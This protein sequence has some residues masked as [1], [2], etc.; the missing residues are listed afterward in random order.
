MWLWCPW[1]CSCCGAPCEQP[2]CLELDFLSRRCASTHSD[3]HVSARLQPGWPNPH[4]AKLLGLR[5]PFRS[6]PAERATTPL[7]LCSSL[8]PT[9]ETRRSR[10]NPARPIGEKKRTFC[11]ISHS[12]SAGTRASADPSQGAGSGLV[13][14]AGLRA[15]RDPREA[16]GAGDTDNEAKPC[17]LIW[18][19]PR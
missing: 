6:H 7:P 4:E 16:Q 13:G 12:F 1:S 15:G 19:R 8:Q 9:S 2:H 18:D 14:A 10:A 3:R 5:S 17:V 11:L